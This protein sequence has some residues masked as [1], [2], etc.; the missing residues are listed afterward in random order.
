MN[1]ITQKA[2]RQEARN[3]RQPKNAANT[4][5]WTEWVDLVDKYNHKCLCCGRDDVP[6]S[7]DHVIPRSL[8]G[9]DTIDNVQPLCKSCNSKKSNKTI[10]YR[11]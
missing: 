10:D 5:T 1:N 2:R 3:R 11:Y 8:G 4:T 9:A 6:M 7:L